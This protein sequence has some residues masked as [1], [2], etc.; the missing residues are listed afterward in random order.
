MGAGQWEFAKLGHGNPFAIELGQ[1]RLSCPK[2]YEHLKPV[3]VAGDLV[4]DGAERL[5]LHLTKR[6]F[7]TG[8]VGWLDLGIIH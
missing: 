3:T 7:C 4:V 2:D 8:Q 1:E 5:W 6:K